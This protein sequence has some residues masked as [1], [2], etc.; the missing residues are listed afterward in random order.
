MLPLF[1]HVGFDVRYVRQL[2]A[3]GVAV[4]GGQGLGLFLE[5][6]MVLLLGEHTRIGPNVI[7]V[8]DLAFVKHLLVGVGLDERKLWV[9]EAHVVDQARLQTDNQWLNYGYLP[10]R[11]RTDRKQSVA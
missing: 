4:L 3:G 6:P 5:K 11:R 2:F 9:V 8:F 10:C 7:H 1:R